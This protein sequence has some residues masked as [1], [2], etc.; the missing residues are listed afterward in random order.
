VYIRQKRYIVEGLKCQGRTEKGYIDE[1]VDN[2]SI[3]PTNPSRI[4]TP[5]GY[6][7]P[8]FEFENEYI[9]IKSPKTFKVMLGQTS[10]IKNHPLSDKQYKKILWVDTN[11]KPVHIIIFTKKIE[12]VCSIDFDNIPLKTTIKLEKL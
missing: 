8:D 3:L 2:K 6:Y 11:V 7:T 1:L 4:K 12:G 10:W 5:H 9:E